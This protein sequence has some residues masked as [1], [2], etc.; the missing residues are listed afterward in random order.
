MKWLTDFFWFKSEVLIG[1]ASLPPNPVFQN[2]M[3]QNKLNGIFKN[4]LSII[5]RKHE[6]GKRQDCIDFSADFTDDY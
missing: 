4:Q 6:T 1:Q 5:T 2:I 3:M